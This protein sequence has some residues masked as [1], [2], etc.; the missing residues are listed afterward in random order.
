MS[1]MGIGLG[2]VICVGCPGSVKVE[3]LPCAYS[4][5]FSERARGLVLRDAV[6]AQVLSLLFLCES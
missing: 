4:C 1:A 6:L 2:A 3:R 5:D